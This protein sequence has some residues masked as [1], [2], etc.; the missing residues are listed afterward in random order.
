MFLTGS[1]WGV[2]GAIARHKQPQTLGICTGQ[3]RGWDS[4]SHAWL[5]RDGSAKEGPAGLNSDV[6]EGDDAPDERETGE[7]KAWR[8]SPGP[9]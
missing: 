6:G 4:G 7:A 8:R 2:K 9:W 3:K 1:K 5:C